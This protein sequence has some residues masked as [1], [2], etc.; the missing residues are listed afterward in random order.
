MGLASGFEGLGRNFS[1]LTERW[2]PD[3]W[4]VCMMLTIA[5][6]G[7]ALGGADA[8]MSESLVAWGDGVWV[9]LE[10][11]MQFTL[12]MIAAH[13]CVSS[14][15]VYRAL[16]R[17]A[18]LPNPTKPRQAVAL[19]ALLSITVAFLNWAVSVVGCALF[20][21]FLCRRNP[22]V[23]VRV[24]AA[25]SLL[26]MGTVWHGGFSGS[27]PLILAT[28]GNPLLDPSI[29]AAVVDR[30]YPITETLLRPFNLIYLVVVGSVGVVTGV[31]LHPSENP[32]TLTEAQLASI[33]P[34]P[35]KE[36][37]ARDRT[38]A[39]R[40]DSFRGW[41]LMAAFLLLYPLGHALLT[42]GFGATWTINAYNTVFL[43]TALLLHSRPTTFLQA[44][45]DGVGPAWGIIVQ[46]PFY[47]GIFGLMQNTDLGLWIGDLFSSVTTQESFAVIVYLYSGLMNLFVPSAGS[48][49]LIEAPY[50]VPAAENVG[51]SVNTLVLAY[52]YGDSTT[53]LVQPF[54]AIP[55]LSILRMRF[56]E[57]AGYMLMLAVPCF[58]VTL[59]AMWIIPVDL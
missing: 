8:T 37:A 43:A 45:R 6:F 58:L 22:K 19:L 40:I 34:E 47:A 15:I 33:L 51:V 3:S 54:L 9:L 12:A 4:V 31:F 16:D 14:P 11:A 17:M 44:C 21:A 20:A 26:G 50:L 52:A 7:L 38:P 28:P 2:I 29:G 53:N 18:Q 30:L 49:W 55:V 10:L 46:F 56:G 35:P 59:L 27:A 39:G 23:D 13:A 36:P 48:K 24:L 57:I 41:T 32:H 5:A 42:R 1:A 25:C